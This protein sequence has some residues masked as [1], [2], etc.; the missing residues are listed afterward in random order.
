MKLI[1]DKYGSIIGKI[2]GNKP[3]N[4]TFFTFSLLKN[5]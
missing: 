1:V 2:K 5:V 4:I 3:S